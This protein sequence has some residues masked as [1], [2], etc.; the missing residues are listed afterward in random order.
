MHILH[1]VL[2]PLTC[3]NKIN[4]TKQKS[5]V[6]ENNMKRFVSTYNGDIVRLA[7]Q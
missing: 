6:M 3:D 4:Q 1:L 2:A 7:L 5:D